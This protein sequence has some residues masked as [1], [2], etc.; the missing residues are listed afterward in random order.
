MS[1]RA[2]PQPIV[3]V[4][5][6][7]PSVRDYLSSLFQSVG[8]EAKTFTSTPEFLQYTLPERPTCLV[9]D[10][11]LPGLSG[12]DLQL[13][14]A[15]ADI[16]I[17]IIFLTGYGDIP[18]SVQAIKAGAV[19]FLT[20][21]FHEQD[22]LHAVEIGLQQDRNRRKNSSEVSKLKANY[23][24]LTPREQE[25]MR[26]VTAGRMNKQIAGQ[27][28]LSEMT[29]KMHRGNMMRKIGANSLAE[30][31]RMADALGVRVENAGTYRKYSRMAG[32]PRD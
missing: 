22:M 29:V 26:H 27:I 28:G 8:L 14:L 10:V 1:E 3:L 15:K 19:E 25:I 2:E 4:V 32:Q 31:V 9:L 21:P 7:E 24:S 5:D 13:A 11:R 17:P 23:N 18:M 12:L 30:L 20:K 6:D 16:N